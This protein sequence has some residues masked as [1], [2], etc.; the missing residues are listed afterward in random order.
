MDTELV[1]GTTIMVLLLE[2]ALEVALLIF[3]LED[4]FPISGFDATPAVIL[5]ACLVQA[6]K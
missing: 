3:E 2:V 5:P 1:T 6:G 4:S